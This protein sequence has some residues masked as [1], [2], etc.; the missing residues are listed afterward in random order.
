MR[1]IWAVSRHT[2]SHC[3]RMKIAVAFILLL[4]L[5][6]TIMPLVLKG[7]GTLAGRIRTLLFYGPGM[8]S[9]L[10][11]LVTVFVSTSVVA[12]DVRT[13]QIFTVATKPLARWQYVIG[14]WLGVVLLDVALLAVAGGVIFAV[15]QH[16]R[17]AEALN[18]ADRQAV[19]SEVFA[20]RQRVGPKPPDIQADLLDRVRR[21][22]ADDRYEE[23]VGS[24]LPRFNQDRKLAQEELYNQLA[25]EILE[26]RQS[27]AP[28][29]ALTWDFEGILPGKQPVTKAPGTVRVALGQN[30]YR[31][32]VGNQDVIGQLVPAG[33][34]KING[35]DA[36]ALRLAPDF[37]EAQF[38]V[39]AARDRAVAGLTAGSVVE[40]MV[41]PS[42]QIA[43]KVS[44][45][46]NDP[47]AQMPSIWIV[48]NPTTG[49]VYR[50]FRKDPVRL[51]AT[52]TVPARLVDS[53]GRLKLTYVNMPDPQTGQAGSIS[54]PSRDLA[55]LYRVGD[56][57][58]NYLRGMALILLQL[59]FLAAVGL[60]AGTFL[61]FPVACLV[62]LTVLP[63][64][65][66]RGFLQGAMQT[67][68]A[69][70]SVLSYPGNAAV[71][72]M[73][74]LMPDF[75]ATSAGSFL[76][77]GTLIPWSH[78]GMTALL[79]MAVRGLLLLVLACL[80]FQRRELARVQV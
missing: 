48:S 59:M 25:R 21:L 35:V 5:T 77:N 63:F 64:G 58:P 76:I 2:F 47:N 55:V 11:S 79:T 24:L 69:F 32:E 7:D 78:L 14:R 31:I 44:P 36:R 62:G 38:T 42:I 20:A 30:A 43:Y 23:A 26:Q 4:A 50:E 54:V 37:I 52:L 66:A 57:L 72:V 28:G 22:Q 8:T 60:L 27:A 6:L 34:V 49:D 13:K 33:P 9:L 41:E 3:L 68:E 65:M 61:S 15:A 71:W 18:A 16:L 46:Q 70:T 51:K 75:A 12:G 56:F 1:S 29:R 80:I 39:E 40:L 45:A 19:E 74:L 10:L 17:G 67:A 53:Q 73:R